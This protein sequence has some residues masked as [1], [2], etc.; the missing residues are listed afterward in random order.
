MFS[1]ISG[2]QSWIHKSNKLA[3][4]ATDVS[5]VGGPRHVYCELDAKVFHGVYL[6]QLYLRGDVESWRKNRM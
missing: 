1:A 6:W 3:C 2:L 4:L 5:Y